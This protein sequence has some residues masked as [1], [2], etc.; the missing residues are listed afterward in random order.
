VKLVRTALATALI[1]PDRT[2]VLV[3][4]GRLLTFSGPDAAL[5]RSVL[6]KAAAGYTL[7]P[8]TPAARIGEALVEHGALGEAAAEPPADSAGP[9]TRLLLC[10]TGGADAVRAAEYLNELAVAGRY[11]IQVALDDEAA[12]LVN[13]QGLRWL[14]GA[15]VHT[16]LFDGE[17]AIHSVL[18][19]W[20]DVIAVLPATPELLRRL[21]T[22]RYSDLVSLV[23]ANSRGRVILFASAPE[24]DEATV[25][26]LE[27]EG[28]S[29]VAGPVSPSDLPAA[30]DGRQVESAPRPE[31]RE[32]LRVV[33]AVSGAVVAAASSAWLETLRAAGCE[34]AIVGTPTA[35]EMVSIEGL[36]QV[37]GDAA[38]QEPAAWADVVVVLPATAEL[39][40]RLAEDDRSDEL[41]ATVADA[42]TVVLVPAMNTRMWS[43]RAVQRAIDILGARGAYVVLP[44]TGFEVAD[45]AGPSGL[46]GIGVHPRALPGL[47]RLAVGRAGAAG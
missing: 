41:A 7:E 43:R 28:F 34:L 13:V 5:A 26:S 20:A 10:V 39:L 29:L 23:V 47:L 45:P 42:E 32:P 12:Q 46:G 37:Y 2:R 19:T 3:P 27:E 30:L 15:P 24:I 35:S 31:P 36:S 11:E 44:G 16:G 1:G 9:P 14:T 40:C 22:G 18:G 6:E 17:T 33:Y 38:P 8:G 4:S 25:R 21:A